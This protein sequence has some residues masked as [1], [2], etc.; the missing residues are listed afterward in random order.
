MTINTP[1]AR[2]H[3]IT[4]IF[5]QLGI[6]LRFWIES[7]LGFKV[8]LGLAGYPSP[9]RPKNCPK[10][11]LITRVGFVWVWLTAGLA[12]E[13]P[14]IYYILAKIGFIGILNRVHEWLSNRLMNL[15]TK[16]GYTA[17][18]RTL[19]IPEYDWKNGTPEEFYELF[20]KRPHPVILRGFMK[21]ADLLTK[22]N[23]DTVMK[24]FSEEEV[25]LTKKEL[26]GYPG[27]LKEVDNPKVYL[28]NSEI[29]FSKY[30]EIRY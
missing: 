9:W 12:R 27:K 1:P 6:R 18:Q 14:A 13:I 11:D 3:W 5:L 30:P 21:D 26:D 29:L 10:Y 2:R 25:F 20:V 24:R 17:G 4:A 7:F 19:A 15:L 28:H 16:D 22:L 23:W 8:L